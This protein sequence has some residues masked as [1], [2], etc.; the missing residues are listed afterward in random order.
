MPKTVADQF[1]DRLAATRA[2]RIYGIAG[3]RLNG[4]SDAARRQEKIE[5]THV[6]QEEVA[7]FAAGGEA[8]LTGGRGDEHVDLAQM[9]LWR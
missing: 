2:K 5:W 7:A 3:D 4:L 1:V 9:N 6:R 8:H